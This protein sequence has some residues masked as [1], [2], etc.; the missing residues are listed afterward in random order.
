[1]ATER[2]RQDPSGLRGSLPPTPPSPQI[3][4]MSQRSQNFA[5]LENKQAPGDGVCSAVVSVLTSDIRPS[6]APPWSL[7]P[8]VLGEE[9]GLRQERDCTCNPDSQRQDKQCL[10]S[11]AF[12]GSLRGCCLRQG[13]CGP[14]GRPEVPAGLG[15]LLLLKGLRFPGARLLLREAPQPRPWALGTPAERGHRLF[16]TSH[17][18]PSGEPLEPSAVRHQ[19]PWPPACPCSRR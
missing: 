19:C 6:Q 4:L 8:E 18:V 3:S 17:M 11:D 13:R 9:A 15:A 7:P 10:A 14:A 1:M 16:T 2:H 5:S 12:S